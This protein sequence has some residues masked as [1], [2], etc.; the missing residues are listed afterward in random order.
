MS[1]PNDHKDTKIF[2]GGLAWKTTT[3]GLKRYFQRFGD[4]L[5]A[6]VVSETFPG[7]RMKSKGYGF[8]TFRDAESAARACENPFP[9]IDER[10]T[11]I[12]RA[13]L[14]AKNTNTNQF[15]QNG[16]LHH[17]QAG[18][19]HQY[20]NGWLNQAAQHQHQLYS[21]YTNPHF[22][23]VYWDPNC[24]QY[25]YVYNVPHNP[26]LTTMIYQYGSTYG[27][28]QIRRQTSNR[29]P[30]RI[31]APPKGPSIL[32]EGISD[33]TNQ[34]ADDNIEKADTEPDNGVDQQHQ[35]KDQEGDDSVQDNVVDQH[36]GRD[37]EG[38]SSGQDNGVDQHH[39][40]D[41]E[42]ESSGQNNGVDQQ[43]GK[44][45]D[46]EDQDNDV[47]QQH[48]G[49]DQDGD[50]SGQDNDIMQDSK[51][52]EVE[53]ISGQDDDIKQDADA[54]KQLD[55]GIEVTPQLVMSVVCE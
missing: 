28:Q 13:Y 48:E 46:G 15:N 47:D 23:Q 4:V 24:G 29:P 6:N 45:Q 26:Y 53:M 16:F 32:T 20:H 43:Q 44:D 54:T 21:Q 55:N 7:G 35:G 42:G 1:Q 11:N 38:E 27:M 49:K 36:Q 31:S 34:E 14:H 52:Q 25:R 39:G 19:W 8:V 30:V 3:D 33:Q 5:D 9:F 2:V 50:G 37:Q 22:P 18:P 17:H 10:Q 12:N 40:K 51:D 41:Q